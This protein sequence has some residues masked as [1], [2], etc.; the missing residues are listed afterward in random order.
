MQVVQREAGSPQADGAEEN[1][2]GALEA[3][4]AW[5]GQEL[6]APMTAEKARRR[7]KASRRILALL[8]AGSS[9]DR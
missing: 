8:E 7:N 4:R 9:V 1:A 6:T 5:D 3:E 2:P